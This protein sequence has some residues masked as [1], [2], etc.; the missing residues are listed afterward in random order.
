MP[1]DFTLPYWATPTRSNSRT[2]FRVAIRTFC[3]PVASLSPRSRRRS[4]PRSATVRPAP[5]YELQRVEPRSERNRR[6]SRKTARLACRSPCRPCP[7]S[8]W[9]PRRHAARGGLHVRRCSRTFGR[10][11]CGIGGPRAASPSNEMSG[12]LPRDDASVLAYDSVKIVSNALSIVSVRTSVPLI[13]ATPSTIANAVRP[14]GASA[15]R[16]LG[17]RP[18]SHVA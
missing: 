7:G 16:A 11:D 2:G 3:R 1:S 15:P 12:A 9:R 4:P 8:S 18:G 6:R 13:I 10:I 5:V 17:A 14:R